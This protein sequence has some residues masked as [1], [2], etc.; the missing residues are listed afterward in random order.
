MTRT[1]SAALRLDELLLQGLGDEQPHHLVLAIGQQRPYAVRPSRVPDWCRL[2]LLEALDGWLTGKCRRC[3]HRPKP[4]PELDLAVACSWRPGRVTCPACEPVTFWR[5]ADD[6]ARARCGLCGAGAV[7]TVTV[8]FG[9]LS[10]RCSVCADC[11][12]NPEGS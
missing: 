7:D 3:I 9:S 8:A 4:W 5:P 10:W 2:Q 1:P 6:E 11:R 12:P